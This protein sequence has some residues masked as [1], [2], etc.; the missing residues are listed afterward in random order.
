MMVFFLI[1]HKPPYVKRN[2][3]AH[4]PK[5]L[6]ELKHMIDSAF[7]HARNQMP[8]R[9]LSKLCSLERSKKLLVITLTAP[10]KILN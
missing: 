3:Q 1:T 5:S 10:L 2:Y 9:G 6:I 8:L 7:I 4:K